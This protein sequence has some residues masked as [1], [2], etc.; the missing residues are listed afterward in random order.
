MREMQSLNGLDGIGI[1]QLNNYE[2]LA[3]CENNNNVIIE[4]EWKDLKSKYIE[5]SIPRTETANGHRAA[6]CITL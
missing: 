6:A 5:V 4:H 1:L 3:S 2:H